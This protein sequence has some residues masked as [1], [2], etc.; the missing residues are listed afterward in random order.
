MAEAEE[1]LPIAATAA[2]WL[3]STSY[4]GS[5]MIVSLSLLIDS[6][7]RFLRPLGSS[8]LSDRLTS[9]TVTLLRKLKEDW[10]MSLLLPSRLPMSRYRSRGGVGFNL[11]SH[12]WNADFLKMAVLDCISSSRRLR[13]EE[14]L[15]LASSDRSTTSSSPAK[16]AMTELL[17]YGL[18]T[19]CESCSWS[20]SY[21]CKLGEI[22]SW[23]SAINMDSF[24]VS[25]LLLFCAADIG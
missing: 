7:K 25:M 14:W 18:F 9:E 19:D 20:W 2:S 21:Y 22:S 10:R 15:E 3:W 17:P 1:L 16:T 5:A 11:T 6:S 4:W 23:A 13:C 8:P 12:F 24:W